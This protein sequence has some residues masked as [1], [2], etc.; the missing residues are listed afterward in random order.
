MLKLLSEWG[1]QFLKG[2]LRGG[3]VIAILL[4][5]FAFLGLNY[6]NIPYSWLL[7]ALAGLWL[8]AL[9]VL[10]F[11]QKGRAPTNLLSSK[12]AISD[13]ENF[14]QA[15]LKIALLGLSDSG[16]T[17]F[18]DQIAGQVPEGKRTEKEYARLVII[19]DSNPS[20]HAVI[21]DSRGEDYSSQVEIC[22]QSNRVLFFVDHNASNQDPTLD[23]SRVHESLN[24]ARQIINSV[25]RQNHLIEKVYIQPNKIDLWGKESAA[26]LAKASNEIKT[27]F[28]AS[29]IVRSVTVL[30]A[31]SMIEFGQA[32]DLFKEVTA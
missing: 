24:V 4:A 2:L 30:P 29:L 5:I 7:I 26:D 27:L 20:E 17:T 9:A 8:F 6:A 28:D 13:I 21:M 10:S 32:A 15:N 23:H 11:P 16:K 25:S 31:R 12:I 19:P 1:S 14:V 22:L 18:L 3:T